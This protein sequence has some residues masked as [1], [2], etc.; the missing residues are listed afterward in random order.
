MNENAQQN[1]PVLPL[2]H[3]GEHEV[4]ENSFMFE[5]KKKKSVYSQILI[6]R[7]GECS[8]TEKKT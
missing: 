1:F 5:K 6:D 7:S 3:S 8:A 4:G 2:L